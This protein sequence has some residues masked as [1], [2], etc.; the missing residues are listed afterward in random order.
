[1]KCLA[2]L[3]AAL[4]TV[5]CMQSDRLIKINGD[6]SGTIVDTLKLGEQ[7]KGMLAGLEQMDQTPAAQK[8]AKKEARLKA[9][10]T[11][12]GTTFVSEQ[13][14]PDGAEKITWAF[15]D[16]SKVKVEPFVSNPDMD[17]KPTS[18]GDLL[19]F[20]FAKGPNAVLTV[21]TPPRPSPAAAKPGAA[22]PAAKKPDENAAQK[23]QMKAMLA[24]LKVSLEVE[25]NGTLVKTDSPFVVGNVVTLMAMDFDQI[26]DAAME[27]L[28]AMGDPT[29]MDPKVME[30]VKGFRMITGDTAIEFKPR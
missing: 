13:T 23:A 20:R 7:A 2:F 19:G 10:G 18:P 16:I 17:S 27:K 14:T 29:K 3:P 12:M 24:G 5:G 11:Q 8:K 6:G 25:V 4:L 15:T 9:Q 22:K 26:D 28:D 21:V 1:L 30:G